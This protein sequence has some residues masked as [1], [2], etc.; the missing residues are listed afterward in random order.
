MRPVNQLAK[1]FG[2]G[3]KDKSFLS[4]TTKEGH[5][6]LAAQKA[7]LSAQ[8]TELKVRMHKARADNNIIGQVNRINNEATAMLT[9]V[10]ASMTR[11]ETK[12]N[13]ARANVLEATNASS[14]SKLEMSSIHLG[15]FHMRT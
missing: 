8:V 2:K 1:I 5:L 9:E 7:K 14:R 11:T 6:S 12:A 10:E 13:E 3:D 15:V 4:L